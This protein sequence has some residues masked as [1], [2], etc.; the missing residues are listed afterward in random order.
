[1]LLHGY[2]KKKEVYKRTLPLIGMI[3]L[4]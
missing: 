3:L 4:N 2:V 1:M